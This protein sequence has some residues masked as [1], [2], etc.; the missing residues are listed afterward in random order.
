MFNFINESVEDSNKVY[1]HNWT[2]KSYKIDETGAVRHEMPIKSWSMKDYKSSEDEF[3]SIEKALKY[4][5]GINGFK[6]SGKWEYENTTDHPYSI[7]TTTK[8][9]NNSNKEVAFMPEIYQELKAVE[10]TVELERRVTAG[11]KTDMIN[12]FLNS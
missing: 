12:A 9:L 1:I 2:A 8:I 3:E 10:L 11:L 4:V 7:F 6:Y 5:C